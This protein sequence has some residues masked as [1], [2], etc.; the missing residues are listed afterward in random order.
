MGRYGDPSSPIDDGNDTAAIDFTTELSLPV[1]TKQ[2]PRRANRATTFQIHEDTGGN[3]P[4]DGRVAEGFKPAQRKPTRRTNLSMFAQPPRKFSRA[5]NGHAPDGKQP[6]S[7]NVR[8]SAG[9][10]SA[11][12]KG[13]ENDA[14]KPNQSKNEKRRKTIYVPSEDTTMPDVFRGIFSPLKGPRAA[15]HA[16]ENTKPPVTHQSQTRK[17]PSLSPRRTALQPAS[18]PSQETR[19]PRDVAGRKTGKENIPPGE[20]SSGSKSKT[21]QVHPQSSTGSKS[22]N[23]DVKRRSPIPDQSLR[24]TN[25]RSPMVGKAMNSHEKQDG[26][27]S[28]QHVSPGGARRTRTSNVVESNGKTANPKSN[29]VQARSCAKLSPGSWSRKPSTS[30][31]SNL[32]PPKRSPANAARS[33]AKSVSV[34]HK[35]PVLSEDIINPSMYEEKWLEH[36]EIAIT[37]LINNLFESACGKPQTG[38]GDSMRRELL[39]HYQSPYFALLYKRAHASVLH[40]PLRVPQNILR[41]GNRSKDDVGFRRKFLNLWLET[42]HVSALRAATETVIGRKIPLTYNTAGHGGRTVR[43]ETQSF[44]ETFLLRNEDTADPTGADGSGYHRTI[45]RSIM[46]IALLDKARIAPKSTMPHCLFLSSSEYK[47]STAVVQA[48]GNMLLPGTDIIR[49]L[50]GLDCQLSYQQRPLQEYE[51][52]IDNLAVDVR[53]GIIVTRLV[54]LLFFSGDQSEAPTSITLPASEMLSIAHEKDGLPLSHHLKVPCKSKAAKIF[55]VQ[56]ALSALSTISGIGAIAESIGPADIVDG[57]REKTIAL[58]WALVGK[59]GLSALVDWD[60][61]RR[62]I[63]RLERKHKTQ[64][65][66]TALEA[67]EPSSEVVES[68]A[69]I[70]PDGDGRVSEQQYLLKKWVSRLAMVMGLRV[71]NF[72]T[73]FA[74]GRIFESVVDEYEGFIKDTTWAAT[75]EDPGKQ[76]STRSLESRLRS[77][78]CSAQFGELLLL[79]PDQDS[80]DHSSVLTENSPASLVSPRSTAASS[81]TGRIFDQD[82][83]LAA[84]AFLCSRL[85]PASRRARAAVTIQTFWRRRR[86]RVDD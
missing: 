70:D 35:Y 59:W 33:V 42:Y 30:C 57:H 32:Q 14:S 23:I 26:R 67:G 7:R 25:P 17:R 80:P 11:A 73:S 34:D 76:T 61:V 12:K 41:R 20:E 50:K 82:F 43:R 60:D 24:N 45:L 56:V 5:L 38:D 75:S 79:F 39:E 72:T 16:E 53:D 22:P 77:L 9:Q 52:R 47:S 6:T 62:E 27:R 51:Y 74:D 85:L 8:A 21:E 71:D 81:S 64:T 83:T 36:Q 46:M 54:E 37:Q 13:A 66:T 3:G 49:A 84:I 19:S 4:Q 55:N 48:L 28:N 58:L 44:L 63:T 10:N 2:K 65:Q 15:N 68:R 29:M 1:F 40:G 78:G 86:R 69:V 18:N 31:S